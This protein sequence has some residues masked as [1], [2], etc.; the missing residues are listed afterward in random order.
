[1][2]D[3]ELSLRDIFVSSGNSLRVNSPS[4]YALI[5]KYLDGNIIEA[6]R[7]RL[8]LQTGSLFARLCAAA[9]ENVLPIINI[10]QL[11]LIDN[12]GGKL[13]E[14]TCFSAACWLIDHGFEVNSDVLAA[15]PWAACGRGGF[16]QRERY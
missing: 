11:R 3:E 2:I 8:V 6:K 9:S 7:T 1:M 15:R 13:H 4:E 12:K 14:I 10:P 16:A 5:K